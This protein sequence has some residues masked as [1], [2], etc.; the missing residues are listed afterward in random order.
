MTDARP[1]DELPGPPAGPGFTM[2][3]GIRV[4]DITTSYAGPY[5][6]LLLADMGAE[7]IKLKRPGAGDDCRHWGPPFLDGE[8]LWFLSVNRN[9]KSIE[10][11][12]RRDAGRKVLLGLAAKADI[13]IADFSRL[14]IGPFLDP[15]KAARLEYWPEG[16]PASAIVEVSNLAFPELLVEI[17]AVAVA[18]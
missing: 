17:E 5:A 18:P 9:K 7:V 14:R 11:D 8:S 10:V 13:V 12:Y 6:S 2:L 15:I 3:A 16:G 1:A 4:L